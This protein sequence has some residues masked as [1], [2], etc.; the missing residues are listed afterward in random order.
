MN[1]QTLNDEKGKTSS[2]RLLAIGSFIVALAFS[3]TDIFVDE[4]LID[5]IITWLIASLSFSGF[6]GIQAGMFNRK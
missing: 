5:T 4:N 3:I 1:I 2:K 6:S